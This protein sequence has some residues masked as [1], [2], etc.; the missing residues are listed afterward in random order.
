MSRITSYEDV[1]PAQPRAIRSATAIDVVGAA[2]I[3]MVLYPQPA[4][5]A[6]IMGRGFPV[7]VFVLSL[8]LSIV[9]VYAIYEA[10]TLLIWART[11][12]MYLMDLGLKPTGRPGVGAAILWALGWT[13]AFLPTLFGFKRAYAAET[14]IAARMS[15][16]AIAST[17][18]ELA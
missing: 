10:A 15:G 13:I 2:V 9:V 16:L 14:G 7:W 11:P 18:A 8:L 12:G 17:K 4:A 1:G 5:R 3:A 6:A